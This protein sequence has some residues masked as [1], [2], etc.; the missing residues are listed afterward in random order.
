MFRSPHGPRHSG[1]LAAVLLATVLATTGGVLQPSAGA[2]E[3]RAALP[4]DS[5]VRALATARIAE[6]LDRGLVAVPASGGI[7]VSWRMFGD[8]CS[9][10]TP[11][12][13]PSSSTAAP[14]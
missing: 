10:T 11:P 6:R 13:S 5:T 9:A 2:A 1:R 12:A 8:D 4:A 3:E 7:L 14:R